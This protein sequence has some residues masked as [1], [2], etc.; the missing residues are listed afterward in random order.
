MEKNLGKY[1]IIINSIGNISTGIFIPELKLQ[2]DAGYYFGSDIDNILIT[3]GHADHIKDITS[4]IHNNTKKV[5]IICAKYLK[6]YLENYLHSYFQL[7]SLNMN[8]HTLNKKI[9][10]NNS[11]K[12]IKIEMFPVKHSVKCVAY[13]I[14]T[15]TNKLKTIFIGKSIKELIEI[16]K[17]NT[18]TESIDNKEILFATDLDHSSLKLL[19]FDEYKNIIIECT[20]YSEEHLVEARNRYH[21]HWVDIE[22]IIKKYVHKNF[23]IIHPS[24]RYI[25]NTQVILNLIKFY[26]N[27]Q[28]S[29][30]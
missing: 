1:Y 25:K 26:P 4:I 19:P 8:N 28:I 22:P 15:I 24:P 9:T 18:I 17:H 27:V 21:L 10:W 6:P 23:L 16:K 14:I 13:G 11:I 3:H 2:L 7:N 12:N 20:F 30:D 29:L 5:N